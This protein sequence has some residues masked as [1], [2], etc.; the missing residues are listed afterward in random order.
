[1]TQAEQAIQDQRMGL[2]TTL[3]HDGN[4]T[5]TAPTLRLKPPVSSKSRLEQKLKQKL[6]H[7]DQE[8]DEADDVMGDVTFRNRKGGGGAARRELLTTLGDGVAVSDEGVLGGTNDQVFGGRNRFGQLQIDSLDQDTTA[9]V[10]QGRQLERGADG[11]AMADDFY[12]RDV[13][14]EYDE[15]DYDAAEQFDDDDVDLGEAEVVVEGAGFGDDDEDEDVDDLDAEEEVIG[16]AE[17]LATAAG[18]RAMLA[19][20]RGEVPVTPATLTAMEATT[21]TDKD[22][23]KVEEGNHM[24]KILSAAEEASKKIKK[25]GTTTDEPPKATEIKP[26]AAA[27]IQVDENGLRII[28]LDAVRREIWLNHGSIPMKRL[29]KIFDV[30]KKSSQERQNKF[31]EM[32]KELCNM[33]ADPVAGRMLVLKQHYS[34]MG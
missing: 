10:E 30:K 15:L 3:R 22:D 11:A 18:F 8:I 6:N 24:D 5:T 2:R 33:K 16:G 9:A 32:V 7:N 21:T 28:S 14:A 17:G 26:T 12:Q 23:D 19:K 34:N 31:L 20:A 1:M 13:Q 4:V 29:M 27:A 25:T